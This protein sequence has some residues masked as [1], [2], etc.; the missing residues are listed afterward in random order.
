MIYGISIWFLISVFRD[1]HL[2]DT[3][4]LHFVTTCSLYLSSV[5][6]FTGVR[7]VCDVTTIVHRFL[8]HPV[9]QGSCCGWCRERDRV[10][11]V[12]FRIAL[13]HVVLR[14]QLSV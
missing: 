1:V 10:T 4:I 8:G 9:L 7:Y 13:V 6:S 3:F 14:I 11:I 5:S 12:Q 2:F